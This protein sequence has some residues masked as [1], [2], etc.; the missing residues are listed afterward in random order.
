MLLTTSTQNRGNSPGKEPSITQ[1]LLL[2][3]IR[4]VAVCITHIFKGLLTPADQVF[5][6]S[7]DLLGP[8]NLHGHSESEIFYR[9]QLMHRFLSF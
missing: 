2:E 9:N 5:A 8:R 7:C 6:S 1:K 4:V 3:C